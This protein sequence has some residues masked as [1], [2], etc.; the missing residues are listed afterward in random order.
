MSGSSLQTA[1]RWRSFCKLFRSVAVNGSVNAYDCALEFGAR[2]GNADIE[3]PSPFT[4][5]FTGFLHVENHTIAVRGFNG[6]P[7]PVGTTRDVT[8]DDFASQE[9]HNAVRS[10][11]NAANL[12]RSEADARTYGNLVLARY[13]DDRPIFEIGFTA[14]QSEG[15]RAQAVARRVSDRITL[16]AD[17]D[18]GLNVNAD[19]HIESIVN[20]WSDGAKLWRVTWELSPAVDVNR[21]DTTE[22]ELGATIDADD[23][24]NIQIDTIDGPPWISSFVYP[25]MFPVAVRIDNEVIRLLHNEVDPDDAS[26]QFYRVERGIDGTTAAAHTAGATVSLAYPWELP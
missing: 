15:H 18:T 16:M 20:K 22:S 2:W 3:N 25:N 26:P 11:R 13:A 6:D 9:A 4:G 23:T 17:N 21:A 8:V 7:P 24:G 10:H 1:L 19:F 14:T 12:F 5:T